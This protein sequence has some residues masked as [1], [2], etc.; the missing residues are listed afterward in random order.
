[1]ERTI[2]IDGKQVAFK[3]NG[4]TPRLYRTMFGR[5]IFKDISLLTNAFRKNALKAETEPDEAPDEEGV[6]VGSVFDVE[7]LEVFE[8]VAYVM[9][10]QADKTIPGTIDEWLDQFS[11]FSIYLVLPEILALWNLNMVQISESKKNIAELTAK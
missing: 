5:D 10:K 7:S 1:M 6:D 4:N 8:N 9:A 11:V 2:E 3:A